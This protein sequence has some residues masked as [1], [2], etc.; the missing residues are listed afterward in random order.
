[1]CIFIGTIHFFIYMKRK[2]GKST[3]DI[4]WLMI[5]V[6]LPMTANLL[7][8]CEI[9][10]NKGLDITAQVLL[11]TLVLFGLM[12]YQK[13]FLNLLPVAARHFVEN[14]SD[15]IIII[16]HEN[17]VVGI[18][19]AVKR[20]FP[21]LGLENYD[22]NRRISMYIQDKDSGKCAK[23]LADSL[24]GVC[25]RDPMRG[26]VQIEGMNINL[27]IKTLTGFRQAATGKMIVL[28]D[29]TEEKRLMDEIRNKNILLTKANERLT[30]S[31][32]M[33]TEA[34]WRMEKFS[35]TIEELA[36][37]RERN[38]FGREVH[39]TVG[40]TLTLLIAIA[41]NVKAGLY[42]EQQE[43]WDEMDKSIEL[44][45]LA[46]NDIRNCL[47]GACVDSFKGTNLVEWMNH[48]VKIN[49]TSETKVEFTIPEKIPEIDA[50]RLMAIYRICQESVTN[51]IRHG[52]AQTVSIIVKVQEDSVRLYIFSDGKG[53]REIVKGYGLTGMEDRVS[54]FGGNISFGS[55]GE[56]GFNV[57]A[58]IP[59]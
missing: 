23:E 32:Q 54:K 21:G 34:N 1:M 36:I 40:H 18:N 8:L 42:K 9:I 45:R 55:D 46:L 26:I 6:L 24:E 30:V 10:P 38:R 12:V 25:F 52:K 59:V 51:A 27:E 22:H 15:G 44:S 13:R 43:I 37:T 29:R 5:A 17:L 49:A 31:N 39:D 56:R 20:L 16:D 3:S 53:C 35:E 7:M 19:D 2:I 14:M 50:A 48:L 57:I 28:E 47:K 41:E 11:L 58:E 4:V 33:L